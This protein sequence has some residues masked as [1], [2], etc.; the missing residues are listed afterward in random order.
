MPDNETNQQLVSNE[1][2]KSIVDTKQVLAAKSQILMRAGNV[3]A[4]NLIKQYATVAE[5][6]AFKEIKKSKEYKGLS[7]IDDSGNI[8]QVSTLEDFCPQFLGRSYRTI[9]ELEAQLDAFGEAFFSAAHNMKLG[10][11]ELRKLRKLPEED[12]KAIINGEAVEQGDVEALKQQIEDIQFESSVKINKLE[13]E[14]KGEQATVKAVRANL[15]DT[16]QKLNDAKELEATRRF[17][18]EPW[19]RDTLENV[20]AMIE[21]RLLIESGVNQLSDIF[22]NF[23]N[24][25]NYDEKAMKLIARSFLSEAKCSQD[26]IAEFFNQV[27]GLLG[28]LY[29]GDITANDVLTDIEVNDGSNLT[30]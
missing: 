8:Q 10:Y 18:Q 15:N 20:K 16:Q 21:A 11:R 6:V 24:D 7:Y 12:Q 27:H 26:F 25:A 22:D 29:Q 23:Q 13:K 5:I 9:K 28:G 2:E 30:E 17:S 14:V 19:K 4:F 3:Q 1:Q